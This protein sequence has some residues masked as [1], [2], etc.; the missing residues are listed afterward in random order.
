MNR[1]KSYDLSIISLENIDK[2]IEDYLI[3]INN[4]TLKKVEINIDNTKMN[5][6]I[7]PYYFISDKWREFI[8]LLSSKN[9]KFWFRDDDCGIDNDSLYHLLEYMN[10]KK[11]EIFL[12]AIPENTD[13]ILSNKIQKY[14]SLYVG[15]HGY[16]H[17]NHSLSEQ[18]EYPPN[19]DTEIVKKELIDGDSKLKTLFKDKYLKVFIPPWFEI[20]KK[21]IQ[22]LKQL[23]YLAVS[24]FWDNQKNPYGII[25]ANCQVDFVNWENAYTFGGEDYILKQIICEL[26]KE[27]KNYHIGLLLHHERMGKETY[28]FLDKLIDVI[29]E[30]SKFESIKDV[31]KYVGVEND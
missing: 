6:N 3:Q 31:I 13:E 8:E 10:N 23:N 24:N 11:I 22:M 12:A 20:D 29:Q 5:I 9:V 30:Y 18:S 16:A 7:E 1:F 25:E 15:Q 14:N 28:M 19:R 27:K 21:T 26:K 4:K 2:M 17:K